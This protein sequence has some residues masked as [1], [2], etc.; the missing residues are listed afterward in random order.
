MQQPGC[1]PPKAEL[2]DASCKQSSL[3]LRL[4]AVAVYAPGFRALWC[5]DA[6]L[7]QE[8]ER[9]CINAH[10]DVLAKLS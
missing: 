10:E 1:C 6:E 7:L 2:I 5:I 3:L 4:A 8:E 9:L